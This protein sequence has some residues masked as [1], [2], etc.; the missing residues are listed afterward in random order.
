MAVMTI[1]ELEPY[2]QLEL[3]FSEWN[4]LDPAGMVA[5]SSGTAALHLALEAMNDV[6]EGRVILPDLTMVAC[7]R[8]VVMA[9]KD[10]RFVDCEDDLQINSYRIEPHVIPL[11]DTIMAV[12]IYG[13]TCDMVNINGIAH[14]SCLRVVE[15]LAEAHGVQPHASTDAACWSFYKNKIVHGEEG[16]AVWFRD[17]DHARLARQL[18]SLG[19]TDAHDFTHVPRG[20]NYRMSNAHASLILP[21]LAEADV[22][23][24]KRRQVEQW[25]DAKVPKEWKMPPR[26]VVWVYD[27][28]IPGMTSER[29]DQL[30]R[31]LNQRGVA[32][33][34]CF[35]PMTTMEEWQGQQPVSPNALRLSQEVIYLPAVPY[36]TE[37]D[38]TRIVNDLTEV[39]EHVL[40]GS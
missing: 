22:N 1:R 35:K 37:W 13:R 11:V 34:H 30:V 6:P 3:K 17:P 28:R 12:H 38:V 10:C 7:P 18:R 4:E 2:E 36:L 5:C 25:Y 19:F 33:R 15:D 14:R 24:A 29:Q 39:W 40:K 16:G 20:H 21:S 9:G 27:L 23:L 8:A 26:D 32:A 31:G